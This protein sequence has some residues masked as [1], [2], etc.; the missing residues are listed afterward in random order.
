MAEV[1]DRLQRDLEKAL[2]EKPIND[3]QS[4]TNFKREEMQPN[5]SDDEVAEQMS[6]D[7]EEEQEDERR[8]RLVSQVVKS[9]VEISIKNHPQSDRPPRHVLQSTAHKN[10]IIS[11]VNNTYE[12]GGSNNRRF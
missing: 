9:Q 5:S 2:E 7:E 10:M 1:E 11:V 8:P 6:E 3:A 4:Q 12:G